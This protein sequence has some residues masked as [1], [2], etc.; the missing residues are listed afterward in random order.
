M[1]SSHKQNREK[2]ELKAENGYGKGERVCMVK[3]GIEG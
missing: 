3:A 1:S 2:L